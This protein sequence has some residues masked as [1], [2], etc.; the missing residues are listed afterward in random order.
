[1]FSQ[2]GTKYLTMWANFILIIYIHIRKKLPVERDLHCVSAVMF[3]EGPH[4]LRLIV[5]I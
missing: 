4:P 1:M 2:L 3:V 5:H